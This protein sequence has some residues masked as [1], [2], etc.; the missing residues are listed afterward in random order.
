MSA[1][2]RLAAA[3]QWA[4]MKAVRA[5][6]LC[7]LLVVTSAAAARCELELG[8][9]AAGLPASLPPGTL[10]AQLLYGAV[11]LVE[12][13]LPAWRHN[14]SVPLAADQAGYLAVEYLVGRDLLPDSWQ[15]DEL[16]PATWA[17]MLDRFLGWYQLDWS[18]P[19]ADSEPD[20]AQLLADLSAALAEIAAAVRPVTVIAHDEQREVVFVGVI[21]NWT[22][23]P[24]LLVKRVPAGV[25]VRE[26]SSELLAQL[27]NCAVELD[28]YALAPVATA[29]RLFVGTGDSTMFVLASEP[30]R[31]Q[32]PLAVD[33][34][35]VRAYLEFSA[36]DV[37][38][39]SEFAAAFSGQEIG[40]GAILSMATQ[41]R[42]NIPPLSIGRYLAVP[43]Q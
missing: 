14:A 36:T 25:S 42:T 43:G 5:A 8:Q 7:L 26:G 33:Q 30:R 35:E 13:T 32:W 19:A 41:I 12:P 21:W 18:A 6:L 31:L 1:P 16:S 29:W 11:E 22:S 39:T 28:R 38:G 27:S 40:L 10:A 2:A 17:E 15:P 4:A 23:Y 3:V 24:R 20:G 9:L 34:A 37:A